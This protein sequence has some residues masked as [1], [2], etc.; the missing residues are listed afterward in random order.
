MDDNVSATILALDIISGDE[1]RDVQKNAITI[2]LQGIQPNKEDR[3]IVYGVVIRPNVV[4]FQDEIMS[5][6]EV[7]NAAHH[8][9]ATRGDIWLMHAGK[10]LAVPLESYIA[11]NDITLENGALIKAGD[12]ILAVKII[13]EVTWQRVK[14]GEITGFSVGGFGNLTPIIRS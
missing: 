3:R 9:M 11:P 4:D 8:W 2:A 14:N 13:D 7:E 6:E 5:P 10:A 1:I 12:W